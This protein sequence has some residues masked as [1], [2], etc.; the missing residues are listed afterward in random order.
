[1]V[2]I[3]LNQKFIGSTDNADE[4][5]KNVKEKR[6]TAKIPFNVSVNYDRD[7]NEIYLDSTRGRTM[8]L[9]IRAENGKILLNLLSQ[10]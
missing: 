7:F 3:Y 4:F 9:I 2:D 10:V 1:M 6:R 8:R 5:I